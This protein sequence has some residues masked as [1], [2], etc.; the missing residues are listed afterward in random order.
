LPWPLP[1]RRYYYQAEVPGQV[2]TWLVPHATSQVLPPDVDYKVMLTFLEFYQT[3]LQV[4]G[5]A[6]WVWRGVMRI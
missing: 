5:W 4:G 3:L 2:V 6:L 1:P